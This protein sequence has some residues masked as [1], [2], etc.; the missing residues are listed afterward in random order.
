MDRGGW[1]NKEERDEN[2]DGEED[3]DEKNGN[4]DNEKMNENEDNDEDGN[5]ADDFRLNFGS[6]SI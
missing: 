4:D 6:S 5:P 3:E 2:E 1:C